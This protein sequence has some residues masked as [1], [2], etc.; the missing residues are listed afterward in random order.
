MIRIRV[1]V[2]DRV[3]IRVRTMVRTRPLRGTGEGDSIGVSSTADKNVLWSAPPY[4]PGVSPRPGLVS[5][6]VD[7]MSASFANPW[8][9]RFFVVSRQ[10]APNR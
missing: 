10:D 2:R 8:D 6:D 1:M 5:G 7:S 4:P 3:R 9:F